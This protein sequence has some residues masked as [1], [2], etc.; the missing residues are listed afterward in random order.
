M[1]NISDII[2]SNNKSFDDN[3]FH[4]KYRCP[5]RTNNYFGYCVFVVEKYAKLDANIC[6]NCHNLMG[7]FCIKEDKTSCLMCTTQNLCRRGN[8]NPFMCCKCGDVIYYYEIFHYTKYR[9]CDV[10]TVSRVW[11]ELCTK[12]YFPDKN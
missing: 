8:L 7:G 9:Y 12:K 1:N 2:L 10:I 5:C 4:V 6:N 3:T 11:C